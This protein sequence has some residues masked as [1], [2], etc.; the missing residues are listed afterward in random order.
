MFVEDED[1]VRL[2]IEIS[3]DGGA[4]EEIVHRL[5]KLDAVG[6]R[7]MVKQKEDIR[8]VFVAHAD[9]NLIGH[10]EQGMDVAQLAKPRDEVGVEVLMTLCANVDGFAKAEGV[11]GHGRTASVE[12]FGVGG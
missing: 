7:L 6:C 4:G 10:F 9:F 1:A 8:I 2:E 5:V 11:H 12:I 3:R